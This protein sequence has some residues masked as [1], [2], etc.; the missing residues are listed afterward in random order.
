M[1]NADAKLYQELRTFPS[2]T[3]FL[4]TGT[5]LQNE[6]KELWSLL[7]FLLPSVFQDWEAFDSWFD[8]TDLEDETATESFITDA[9]KHDLM[10]KIHI[11][12]QP[13]MLRRV[14]ADVAAYLPKKR[15]YILY[16]PMTREQTD[17]Y[18]ALSDKSIDTR[19]FLE[20]MVVKDLSQNSSDSRESSAPS[21]PP[22]ATNG[23]EPNA[24]LP[25]R[26]SPRKTRASAVDAPQKDPAP[27]A[28][29]LMMGKKASAPP[30]KKSEPAPTKKAAQKPG[31]RKSP[32]NL[33]TPEPK[34]SKSSRESTPGSTRLRART[35]AAPDAFSG[36]DEDRL[37]DEEFEARLVREHEEKELRKLEAAQSA[38]DF[39]LAGSLEVASMSTSIWPS[40]PHALA[41]P[42]LQRKRYRRR[43]WATPSCSSDLLATAPITFTTHGPTA[44]GRSTSPSLRSPGRCSC[45]IVSCPSCSAP[46]T[47]F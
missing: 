14:K 29:A 24:A 11:V 4:I 3:R 26:E 9:N 1:K 32:P 21:T 25:I 30:K 36:V 13:L 6:M 27:N 41:N 20:N 40:Y 47:R 39:A 43:S 22:K 34:S 33:D 15:E 5:P 17:L 2:A 44:S 7:H 12:L 35:S 38:E 16:A 19:A 10:R 45:W 28:F 31:K 46:A 18:K 42:P 23:A 37:D 8:F